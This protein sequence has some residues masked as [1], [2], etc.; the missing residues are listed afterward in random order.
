MEPEIQ[1]KPLKVLLLH[2][3]RG[4]ERRVEACPLGLAWL[5]THSG[6]FGLAP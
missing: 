2:S 5:L 4:T 6:I 1:R 3:V